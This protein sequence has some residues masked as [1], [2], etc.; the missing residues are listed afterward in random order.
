MPIFAPTLSI[1]GRTSAA[2][3]EIVFETLLPAL[4]F[5]TY[6]FQAKSSEEIK[7]TTK[8]TTNQ[9]CILQNQVPCRDREIR[10]KHDDW[11][12]LL[13]QYVRLEF[14]EEG[15]LK[16]ITDRETNRVLPF[17]SQGFYWYTSKFQWPFS[18]SV[19]GIVHVNL[20]FSR[21]QL[22]SWIPSLRRLLLSTVDTHSSTGQQHT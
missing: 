2:R 19:H 13:F 8:V 11:S 5:N 12:N 6:Y 9:A 20:R 22:P 3:Y 14:D 21:K 4:G 18:S 16:N 1:P 10:D 15:Q 17:S 7:P